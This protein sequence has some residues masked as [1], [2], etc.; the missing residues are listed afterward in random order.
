[1]ISLTSLSQNAE[2]YSLRRTGHAGETGIRIQNLSGNA[3]EMENGAK[4]GGVDR[5]EGNPM[6]E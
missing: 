1:M 3:A 6:T 2:M 4:V 5:W